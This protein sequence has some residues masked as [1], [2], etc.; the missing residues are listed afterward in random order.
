M[1]S[2]VLAGLAVMAAAAVLTYALATTAETVA[3]YRGTPQCRS[4]ADFAFVLQ[5]RPSTAPA[6]PSTCG[7]PWTDP[8]AATGPDSPTDKGDPR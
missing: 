8:R 7:D 5:D 2:R 1:I 4:G 6:L 3:A